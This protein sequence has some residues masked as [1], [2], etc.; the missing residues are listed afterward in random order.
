MAFT[1]GAFEATDLD[2]VAVE[3][4]FRLEMRVAKDISL[5]GCLASTTST[6][7][8]TQLGTGGGFELEA[9]DRD[10]WREVAAET[11]EGV[12]A[13]LGAGRGASTQEMESDGAIERGGF[14]GWAGIFSSWV[15]DGEGGTMLMFGTIGGSGSLVGRLFGES[16]GL[17][18]SMVLIGSLETVLC[19]LL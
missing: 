16:G 6:P 11:I 13:L 9:W 7:L 15:V 1:V 10:G 8:P 18:G 3:E 17:G 19:A 12:Y 4:G 5:S 14:G 2:G